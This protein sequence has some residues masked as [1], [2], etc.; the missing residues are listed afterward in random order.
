MNSRGESS[1]QVEGYRILLDNVRE[2]GIFMMDVDRRII[3][4]STGAERLF[5][6]SDAEVIGLSADIIFTDEDRHADAPEQETAVATRHGEASDDRFHV[7]KDGTAFWAN[8]V[9]TALYNR[10]GRLRGFAKVLRDNTER[11]ETEERLRSLNERLEQRVRERTRQVQTLASRLTMAEQGERR[12]I[13]LVLHDDLQQR[14]YSAQMKLSLIERDAASS[15]RDDIV[16]RAADA[17]DAIR[18]AIRTTRRLTVDLSPPV[19]RDEGLTSAVRWLTSLMGE[20]HELDVDVVARDEL[21]IANEDMRVLLFQAVREL[22]FNVVKHAGADR[23]EVTLERRDQRVSITVQD[24]G[25]GFDLNTI[26]QHRDRFGLF[27]VRERL[28]LFEGQVD[29]DSAPGRGARVTISV[30]IDIGG[31]LPEEEG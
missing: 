1:L 7:R 30:P 15:A 24:R 9:L 23:A 4:W 26:E 25:R 14:L 5:G 3:E 2:Y 29:I 18:E 20:V 22:L 6:Y 11:R 8:G 21:R 12:R 27:A 19:L 16:Q 13:S 10:D 31:E 17:A 28:S